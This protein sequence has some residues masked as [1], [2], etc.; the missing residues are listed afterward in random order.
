M[1][2]SQRSAV[3]AAHGQF[4]PG[5]FTTFQTRFAALPNSPPVATVLLSNSGGVA[6]WG[7]PVPAG[8]GLDG[9]AF[10]VQGAVLTPGWNSAG[11]VLSDSRRG[12]FGVL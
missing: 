9:Q 7:I 12:V 10:F 8:A 2:W 1:C 5:A 4:A 3:A 11:A 6:D